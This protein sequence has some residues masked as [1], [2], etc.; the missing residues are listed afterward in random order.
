MANYKSKTETEDWQIPEGESSFDDPLLDC[1]V[2]LTKH[3]DR[4]LSAEALRAGLPLENARFTP[5]L[6]VRAAERAGLSARVLKRPLAKIQNLVLPAVLLL[7]NRQACLLFNVDEST[8]KALILEPE[9]GVG[10]VVVDLA[11][12]ASR[13]LGHAIFVRAE[14]Q[15]DSRSP[16]LF[17][18][19][20][21]HWFWGTLFSSW[22]IYRDVLVASFL[23]SLFALASPLFIMNVYDRVVPNNA[24]ETL[25]VLATGVAVVYLFDLMMRALRGY[26]ID[27][28]GKKADITLSAMIFER[29]MGLK[30][31]ARPV[32]VG[33]FASNLREFDSIRDF[34]T[35]ATITT[36]VD[37]PF[38]LLFLAVI[39]FIGGPIVLIPAVG[40][41]LIMLY[42][43]IIQSP[44]RTAVEKTYRMSTQRNATLV[45]T[46][47][48]LETVK[49]LGAEGPQQRKWEQAVGYIAHWAVRSRLLSASVVNLAVLL[50]QMSTVGTVVFGVYLIG[51]GQMSMGGL[52]ACVILTGRAMAPTAQVAN[53]ATRFHQA[54]AALK[55]LNGIMELPQ[56]RPADR[57]F[58]HR[59]IFK[60]AIEFN[61]VSFSYSEQSNPVLTNVS[62]RIAPGEKVAIIGAIG[63]GK[64]TIEKLIMGLYDPDAGAVLLDG[65]D[66]RQIDPADVRRNIGYTAQDTMLFFGSVRD[67][68]IMGAPFADD[69]AFLRAA[70]TGGV[71]DFVS[72]HPQGFDML[73]GERGEGLSGGQRQTIA[74]AR[75]LL[76]DPP[77]LLLDEPTNSMDNSTEERLK[78]RLAKNIEDKT[79]VMVTH[80][81]SLLELVQ[82]LIV[83]DNGRVV[84]DGPKEQV[85]A[86][87]AH[88]KL[89][90]ARG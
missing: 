43:L 72:R 53:L 28:A 31:A 2:V 68:I 52:I 56:E 66:L 14:H 78:S 55:S 21:R 88:G 47:T 85:L 77:I 75:A 35:S 57:S 24:V 67:N 84:A 64:T 7:K 41:P 18:L 20:S 49:S 54:K 22:R 76:L 58:L 70:V 62:F 87:L 39:Y 12:L 81:A 40:M 80:R 37:L 10:E 11:E 82:R 86:A 26:F 6:F 83:L 4:P 44:L 59:P 27:I 3:H 13:Y 30:M 71:T 73:V 46:L 65:T 34:I 42:G 79:V 38:A 23:I 19:S 9:S 61:N 17:Q 16:E 15:F 90:V 60:G 48:G 63:S 5:N 25:W 74:I 36:F 50:Q 51:E 1:L 33:A 29:V 45:E 32:S 8:S 89:H 69:G